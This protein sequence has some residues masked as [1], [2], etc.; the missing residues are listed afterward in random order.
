MST[1]NFSECYV[2]RFSQSERLNKNVMWKTLCSTYIQNYIGRTDTV[3]DIGAGYCEFINNIKCGQR[4]AVDLNPD[5]RKTA[6]RD[7]Y[8]INK[9][10]FDIPTKYNH[11]INVVFLSNFLEHLNSKDEILNVLAKIYKLLKPSGKIILLQPNIDLVK[12]AYWD[13]IDHKVALN[14]KSI[15][16]A[17]TVSGFKISTFIK[18]FLPYTTKNSLLP[19]SPKLLKIY[20]TI[21]QIIRPFTGQ[22]FV[23]AIKN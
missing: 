4:I 1:K 21:P 20:L 13:F 3:M 7:V 10:I 19:I 9:S 2:N 23:V 14:T 17:L 16:E 12:E 8:V 6:N 5:T 15:T 11:S 22:S 18:K